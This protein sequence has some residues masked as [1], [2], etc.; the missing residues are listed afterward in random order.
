VTVS[1]RR[2]KDKDDSVEYLYNGIAARPFERT[3]RL[4]DYM[5]VTG[6]QLKDGLLHIDLVREIP[7]ERK[8]RTI[9]INGGGHKT[10]EHSS[11]DNNTKD[12]KKAA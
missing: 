12:K 5:K 3:F 9:Q 10:I 7:E 4:A 11:N 2:E 8:P 6:A 1:G